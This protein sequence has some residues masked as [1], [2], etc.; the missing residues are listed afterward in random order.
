MGEGRGVERVTS[1]WAAKAAER[2]F[3]CPSRAA[4]CEKV[5]AW[6]PDTTCPDQVLRAILPLEPL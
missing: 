3:S 6:S 2:A 5:S 1:T 4:K